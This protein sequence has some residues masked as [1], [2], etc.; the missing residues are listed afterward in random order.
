RADEELPELRFRQ[1]KLSPHGRSTLGGTEKLNRWPALQLSRRPT[2]HR[3][4]LEPGSSNMSKAH[5]LYALPGANVSSVPPHRPFLVVVLQ[6][7]RPGRPI[8]P[9]AAECRMCSSRLTSRWRRMTRGRPL[10]QSGEM[11]ATVV[12]RYQSRNNRWPPRLASGALRGP[13]GGP[14]QA[15]NEGLGLE[16]PEVLDALADADIAD[17]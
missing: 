17:R 8:R 4:G 14:E 3:S 9:A 10:R 16:W 6:H 11:G 7:A 1:A 5:G 15:T 2:S 13:V 12:D